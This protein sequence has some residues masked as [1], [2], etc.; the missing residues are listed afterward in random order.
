MVYYYSLGFFFEAN[1]AD[2]DDVHLI[3]HFIW[4]FFQNE[5]IITMF[6]FQMIALAIILFITHL[7]ALS[8]WLS[9]VIELQH[10]ISNNVT[11]WQV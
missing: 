6:S 1:S 7:N 11:F 8:R 5:K 2:P 3:R 9:N 4:S 10:V